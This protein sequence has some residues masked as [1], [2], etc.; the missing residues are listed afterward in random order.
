LLHLVGFLYYFTYIDDTQIKFIYYSLQDYS[1]RFRCSLHPSSGVHKAVVA[2]AGT[3]HV[4]VWS[5]FKSV[6]RCPRSGV[7][8]TMSWPNWPDLGQLLNGF[9]P[10]PHRHMTR[11]CDCNY[12]F[13]YSWWWVQRAPVTCR[14][15]L[16]WIINKT[17]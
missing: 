2:I 9:K 1:I 10:T 12:S 13:M 14:V 5:R 16:Q 4:S 6:K 17:A 7:Y 15:I 3:S 11:S 8:L